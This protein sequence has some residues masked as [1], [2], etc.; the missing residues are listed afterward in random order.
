MAYVHMN[1]S[2]CKFNSLNQGKN[3]SVVKGV[4]YGS[5]DDIY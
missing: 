3:Y 2:G 4:I 1:L 5:Y